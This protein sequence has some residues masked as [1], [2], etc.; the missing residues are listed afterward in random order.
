L[1]KT[2]LIVAPVIVAL[3]LLYL[4]FWLG[5]RWERTALR[6]KAEQ[7]SPK[8]YGDLVAFVRGLLN[9]TDLSDPAYL[10]QAAKDKAAEL[11]ATADEHEAKRR[12]SERRRAGY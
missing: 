7:I 6:M 1:G 5:K 2:P 10:P 3:A 4:A 8:L 12:R 11:V 9:P